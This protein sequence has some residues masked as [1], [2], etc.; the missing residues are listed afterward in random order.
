MYRK[1]KKEKKKLLSYFMD[2]WQTSHPPGWKEREKAVPLLEMMHVAGLL[3]L[4]R[5]T[6]LA[7]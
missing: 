2:I 6:V 3:S 5:I 1:K 7:D 4:V